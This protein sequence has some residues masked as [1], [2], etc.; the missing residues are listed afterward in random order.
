MSVNQ[1]I[2]PVRRHYNQWVVNETL[3]DYAL[4]FTAKKARRWSIERV[5]MTAL[6]TTAFLALEA[7][8]AAVTL[9]YG[10]INAAVAM[11]VV[12]AVTFMVGL[13]ICRYAAYY[14][15]DIDLLTRGAG[16]GY[17]GS[18]I[19]SLVY[20]SFTFI[21]FAIEAAILA[22]ALELLFGLPLALG[23][24]LCS[25][26]VIPIVTHGFTLISRFQIGTQYL[27]L[28]LQIAALVLVAF[29]DYEQLPSWMEYGGRR[30]QAEQFDLLVF[31]AAAS[32]LIAMIAQL[33]EQV[34]YLRFLPQRT[35]ANR[36]RWN[37]A[38]LF[39][40]PGW[41]FIG[42]VKLLLGSFL[43]Y[44]A[45]SEGMT[46]TEAADP[47]HMYQRVYSYFHDMPQLGLVIAGVMVLISQ[48]KI[49]ITNAYA[50]SIAWSNFFSRLTHSHPGRVVWLVFNV[51]IALL[52]MELGIYRVLEN[53]LGIFA[54]V[55]V[56]WLG[57]LAADLAIN[58]RLGLSPA[59]I[60]FKR[61]HLYDI[62][63]VGVGS[64][65]IASLAGML[66]YLGQFG[67]EAKALT[68]FITLGCC[69]LA[70]PL[71]AWWTGGRFY[72]ARTSPQLP[73]V[74]VHQC[75]ICESEFERE[76]VAHCSAYNG[77]ICSLCCSLDARCMD[78][79][80]TDARFSQQA[81]QL[82]RKWFSASLLDALFSRIGRFVSLF[83]LISA[84]NAGLLWVI[85]FEM[86]IDSD[87]PQVIAD[88]LT[89]LYFILTIVTGVL[90]W[91]FLLAN[92]SRLVAQQES[93]RQ[94]QRLQEEIDAHYRTDQELQRA[95]EAAEAANYAKSRYLSGISHELRTPLQSILGYTQLLRRDQELDERQRNSLAIIHRSGEHLADLIEGLL[96]ISRI[97]AGRIE[98]RRDM[99]DFHELLQQM[100][101]IFAPEAQAKGVEFLFTAESA[102]PKIVRADEKR[103]RQVLTNLLSNA[104]K[105]T[106]QGQVE[107]RV[108]YRAQV[109]E[110]TVLDS[111]CGIAADDLATIFKPFER[112]RKLGSP[113]VAGTGLGLT[114]V[115]LL[116][117]I[118]GG[119]I[120][121]ES[122]EGEGS[123]FTLTLML[124][125]V[126]NQAE[127][128]EPPVITGYEGA[129]KTVMVVDD[130]PVHRGL[131]ADML[132]P[133]GF[134]VVEARDAEHCLQQAADRA[135]DL[136]MLDVSMPG[137][138]GH[139]LA[140]ALR[141]TDFT[142]PLLM[143]SA[144][145]EEPPNR[146]DPNLLYNAYL[147]KP[148]KLQTLLETLAELMGIEWRQSSV[149]L[150]TAAPVAAPDP[151]ELN[152]DA[153]IAGRLIHLAEIG[154]ARGLADALDE[155]ERLGQ[156]PPTLAVM[157]RELA[158][159]I[160]FAK[161]IHVL[162]E[163]SL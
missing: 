67:P 7:L 1:Q 8:G 84:I 62:N 55:A 58:K 142:Q 47:T 30:A 49:N 15:V 159:Q 138:D 151:A 89:S 139:E 64:M 59:H 101:Q 31:G 11:V 61:A 161:V 93:D 76:D 104:V 111:G 77:T 24:V 78:S 35:A 73:V 38:V 99:V 68:H 36:R 146:P 81:R 120:R 92:E 128:E 17:L 50:G 27:W 33:G 118:M 44:L 152:I 71:L 160:Q 149:I 125:S 40:G 163:H 112:V 91:L 107:F 106:D 57:T 144:N 6:G 126:V 147:L 110:F 75:V 12:M 102:L 90:I 105:F 37:L 5:A 20:A 21:F 65:L 46:L 19:T 129:R 103:L 28:A 148:V 141:S 95:K 145:A 134:D 96:D 3:E 108:R 143:L 131:M 113:L 122:L 16:F 25:V 162:E 109:A 85:Y 72:L 114:I 158:A 32:V 69:M 100:Q 53:V 48:M 154:Y 127:V 135:P 29:H 155:M 94:T 9:E 63:P 157:V 121:V 34:D 97:E 116:T 124:S 98:L 136:F 56:A 51:V 14:G 66:A 150:P 140:A 10:F 130:D 115:R 45:V 132:V 13:P 2:F 52:L 22:M 87:K 137:K 23:Y 39:A 86:A 88:T 123:R 79:C 4:R 156:I 54:I 117:E 60:E 153:A 74:E 26:A 133:L 82:L 43:A 41:V 18:T 42:L 119:D 70:A 83:L 80:K